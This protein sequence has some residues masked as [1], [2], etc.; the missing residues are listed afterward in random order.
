MVQ[1]VQFAPTDD[2][3]CWM[4]PAERED[5]RKDRPL[6][7]T[8]K[9]ARR[10]AE[11]KK[12]LQAKGVSGAGDKKELQQLRALN[13]VPISVETNGIIEGWEGKAKGMLQI[14]FE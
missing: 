5:T 13:D 2:G 8:T 4:N 10:V 6:G 3:P 1:S 14:L 11:L 12:D 9:S 7:K